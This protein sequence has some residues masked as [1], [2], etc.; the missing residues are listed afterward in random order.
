MSATGGCPV[1][2]GQEVEHVQARGRRGVEFNVL[3]RHVLGVLLA[4]E[5][6]VLVMASPSGPA[7]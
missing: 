1:D 5:N 3:L 6:A 2:G 7:E 4:L